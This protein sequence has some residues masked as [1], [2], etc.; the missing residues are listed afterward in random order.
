MAFAVTKSKFCLGP[1]VGALP[2]PTVE[3]PHVEQLRHIGGIFYVVRNA[4]DYPIATSFRV[5]LKNGINVLRDNTIN[6][7][8]AGDRKVLTYSDPKIEGS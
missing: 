6:G 8:S 5:Q 2:D 7:L 1:L 4:S 3:Q